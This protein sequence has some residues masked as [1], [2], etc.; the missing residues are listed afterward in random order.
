M[1]GTGIKHYPPPVVFLKA[2]ERQIK[3]KKE[4][5]HEKSKENYQNSKKGTKIS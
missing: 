1:V 2:T 4:K 5:K 3:V